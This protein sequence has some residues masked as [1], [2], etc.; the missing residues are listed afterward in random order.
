MSTALATVPVEE[1]VD[2]KTREAWLA[3]RRTLGVGASEAGA[4]FGLSPWASRFALWVDKATATPRAIPR[5]EQQE[6]MD[7]GRMLEGVIAT[8]YGS[9]TQRQLW[10]FSDFCIARHPRVPCMFATPDR[11]IL[12][13]ADRPG[14]GIL[15][16]KNAGND[17][18]WTNGPPLYVQA[19]VQHELA[20]TGRQWGAVAVL[21]GGN[22]MQHWDLERNE[23]FIAELE[24]ECQAFWAS[25]ESRDPPPLDE[26][27]ATLDAL[28]RMHPL[29]NGETT[30]LGAEVAEWMDALKACKADIKRL[31]TEEGRLEALVRDAMGAFTFAELPGGRLLSLKHQT[32]ASRVQIYP[33]TTFRTLREL[34]PKGEAARRAPKA[35]IKGERR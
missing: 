34:K 23:P 33:E 1:V 9:V 31:E 13:A 4:L 3:A 25:V 7:W 26:H 35:T 20:V 24:E 11:W 6:R 29:D 27:P 19:Q 14:Q 16:I 21:I 2:Y 15:Q 28:K 12:E 32:N 18:A 30:E 5:A 8:R 17:D 22:H 10:S